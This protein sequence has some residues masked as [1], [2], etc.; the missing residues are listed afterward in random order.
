MDPKFYKYFNR[1]VNN[2]YPR[3][4]R[5]NSFQ[6]VPNIVNP[7]FSGA[8]RPLPGIITRVSGIPMYETPKN[9]DLKNEQ[10]PTNTKPEFEVKPPVEQLSKETIQFPGQIGYGETKETNEKKNK[11][12]DSD[13]DS[14]SVKEAPD[15]FAKQFE[16]AVMKVK[17]TVYEPPKEK[18]TIK[19]KS[20]S[21]SNKGQNNNKLKFV[22]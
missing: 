1:G 3:S 10:N 22:D 19:R 4:V 7:G 8:T 6:A 5:L 2:F 21:S 20:S 17:E 14:E 15:H 12:E 16:S 18:K 13:I 9:I 11:D